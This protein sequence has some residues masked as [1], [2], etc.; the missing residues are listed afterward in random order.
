MEKKKFKAKIGYADKLHM[1]FALFL[2]E[3]E[4]AN[5]TVTVKNMVTGEQTTDTVAAL[6]PV[7]R[8]TIEAKRAEPIIVIK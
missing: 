4:I 8:A 5:G 7:I 1:P 3:D 6:V 2:G